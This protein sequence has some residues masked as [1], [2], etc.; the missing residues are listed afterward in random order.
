MGVMMLGTILVS[1][2]G[3]ALP[4]VVG[5]WLTPRTEGHPLI[6]LSRM[7]ANFKRGGW[8][9]LQ[10]SRLSLITVVR[11]SHLP[12]SIARSSAGRAG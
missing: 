8:R 6:T 3:V 2:T 11:P 12:G 7:I 9:L 4:V 5:A 10:Q 1:M